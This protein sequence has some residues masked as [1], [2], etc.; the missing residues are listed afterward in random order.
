[1]KA[2]SHRPHKIVGPWTWPEELTLPFSRHVREQ[3]RQ[4]AFGGERGVAEIEGFFEHGTEPFRDHAIH[5]LRSKFARRAIRLFYRSPHSAIE[6]SRNQLTE[7][8][9]IP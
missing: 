7:Q 2:L 8:Q 9:F 1:K 5:F 4:T 6:H 3:Q